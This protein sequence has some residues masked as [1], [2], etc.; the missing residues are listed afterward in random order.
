MRKASNQAGNQVSKKIVGKEVERSE[1]LFLHRRAIWVTAV[2]CVSC[3]RSD[4]AGT[5]HLRDL[6][7]AL[8]TFAKS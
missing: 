4:L 8:V 5:S 6:I 1:L 2:S 7:F 3:P